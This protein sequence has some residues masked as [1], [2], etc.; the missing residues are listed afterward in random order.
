MRRIADDLV[1]E[2][3]A[4]WRLRNAVPG[5][6]EVLD[7]A[8]AWARGEL[9][10]R[11]MD[12]PGEVGRAEPGGDNP[13]TRVAM[14]WLE[15]EPGI[16]ALAAEPGALDERVPGAVP[17]TCPCW[18]ATTTR[19]ARWPSPGS[20]GGTTATEPGRRSSSA[21]TARVRRRNDPHWF[22]DPS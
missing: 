3:R 4:G 9:P 5:D 15:N 13:L 12:D 17:T 6:R 14:A 19:P 7:T 21:T 1:T 20:S 11:V 8:A 22:A 16:R 10:D 18:P 2:H